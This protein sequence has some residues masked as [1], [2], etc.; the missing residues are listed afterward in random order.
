MICPRI[1]NPLFEAA[2]GASV[3]LSMLID[4]AAS[5][6][7]WTGSAGVM[8]AD[9]EPDVLAIECSSL[10]RAWILELGRL[11]AGR[12]LLVDCPVAGRPDVAETGQLKVFAGGSKDD[13]AQAE[14]IVRAFSTKVTHFGPLADRNDSQVFEALRRKL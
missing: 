9:L 8:A 2:S 6:S 13:V 1:S 11:L 12:A 10:S 3:I 14:V 4:D 7:C 5:R